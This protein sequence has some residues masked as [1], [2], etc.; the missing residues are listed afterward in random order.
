MKRLV[1]IL[2]LLFSAGFIN[3][4][5]NVVFYTSMG[6]FMI[7]IHDDLVPITGNNFLDLVTNEF[8]DGVIFHRVI[9]NFMVQSGDPTGTGT[10]GPGYTI[11]DEFHPDLD[12]AQMTIS[13]ANSGPNSGGSQFFINLVNNFFL[14][15]DVLPLT[16]AHAVFG[17]VIEGFEVVQDIGGVQTNLSDRP[18]NTVTIDSI[19]ITD[20]FTPATIDETEGSIKSDVSVY[21]NPVVAGS[22]LK[23]NSTETELSKIDIYDSFGKLISTSNVNLTQG[24][25]E[26]SLSPFIENIN[27]GGIYIL[28]IT[29][30]G[31]V[32]NVKISI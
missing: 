28:R 19:R 18:I 32:N 24:V 10:G 7:E 14:D 27:T 20:I 6:N 16:S 5:T 13:M 15:H 25:N 22:V 4:Q 30:E 17:T 3:A 1:V 11:A 29:M 2:Y 8:Y 9:D 31:R 12:N 21:P 26:L 23:I